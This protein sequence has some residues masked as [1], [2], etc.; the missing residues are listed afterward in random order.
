M[1]SAHQYT[2][3]HADG[4]SSIDLVHGRRCHR[5]VSECA[6][7]RHNHGISRALAAAKI[8]SGGNKGTGQRGASFIKSCDHEG[9]HHRRC[10]Y[11]I[12]HYYALDDFFLEKEEIHEIP[13][14]LEYSLFANTNLIQNFKKLTFMIFKG[15]KTKPLL[16]FRCFQAHFEM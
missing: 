5:P 15:V 4:I 10:R 3:P 7:N 9:C 16:L 11:L 6:R 1:C 14:M 12:R 13:H 2:V 8:Q